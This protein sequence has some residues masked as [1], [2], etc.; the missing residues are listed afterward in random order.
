MIIE[1]R[2][3]SRAV[4]LERCMAIRD[5]VFVGEQNVP[6]ELERDGR[7]DDCLHYLVTMDGEIIGTARVMVMDDRF[8]F[9]RVAVLPSARG[10]G[11]GGKLMDFMMADLAQRADAGE[12]HFFLSS[13]VDAVPFYE[14]LGFDSCSDIYID[15]G[16]E[17]RDMKRRI[18]SPS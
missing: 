13:Q 17:H 7:D 1:C 16:I 12:K 11:V 4:E 6:P 3:A 5:N 10:A 9:Q 18:A 14:R 15:A 8:K 2:R